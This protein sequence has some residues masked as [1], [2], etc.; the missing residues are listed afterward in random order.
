MEDI[1]I[2]IHNRNQILYSCLYPN[3]F[4]ALWQQVSGHSVSGNKKEVIFFEKSKTSLTMDA[5]YDTFLTKWVFKN[6]ADE[7]VV[8]MYL[9]NL[10]FVRGYADET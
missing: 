6:T 8:R 4:F 2:L 9:Y 5:L 3:H 1:D 10:Y 7:S